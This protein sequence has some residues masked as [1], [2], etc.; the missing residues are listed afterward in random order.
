[1]AAVDENIPEALFWALPS[2]ESNSKDDVV[3]SVVS[4]PNASEVCDVEIEQEDEP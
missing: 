4:T 3:V 1:M 2:T